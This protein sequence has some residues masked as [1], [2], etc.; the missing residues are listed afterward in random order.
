M[1]QSQRLPHSEGPERSSVDPNGP[2]SVGPSW[3]CFLSWI[4]NLQH[5]YGTPWNQKLK[6]ILSW[7]SYSLYWSSGHI[8]AVTNPSSRAHR[9]CTQAKCKTLILLCSINLEADTNCP[10]TCLGTRP[11]SC[12]VQESVTWEEISYKTA[13]ADIRLHGSNTHSTTSK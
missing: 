8:I 1:H 10:E 12:I 7:G 6:I 5:V 2:P 11:L 4:K 3:M 13:Q 9:H